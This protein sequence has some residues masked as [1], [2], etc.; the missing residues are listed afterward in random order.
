MRISVESLQ[1]AKFQRHRTHGFD[2]KQAKDGL[3]SQIQAILRGACART[4]HGKVKAQK[5]RLASLHLKMARIERKEQSQREILKSC[6]H[7]LER[8]GIFTD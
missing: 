1:R 7:E 5:K 4:R 8:R 6:A 3:V 2:R